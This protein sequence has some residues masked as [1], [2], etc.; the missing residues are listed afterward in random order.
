[1]KSLI[2][3]H[4]KRYIKNNKNTIRSKTLSM[5]PAGTVTA[6]VHFGLGRNPG[7][8]SMVDPTEVEDIGGDDYILVW[9]TRSSN[10]QKCKKTDMKCLTD[11]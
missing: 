6:K 7:E 9:K 11:T 8:M 10:K 2:Q 1:M 4:E 3:P 5:N